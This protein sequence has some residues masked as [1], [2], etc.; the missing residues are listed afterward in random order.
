MNSAMLD[1]YIRSYLED[2][3]W[4][5]EEFDRDGLGRIV[6]L[7][8][9]ARDQNRQILLVGNGGS[10]AAASHMACDLG[11]GTIN[12]DDSAFRRF[13]V[14]SLSDNN[15]LI[16][17]IGNDLSYEEVFVEQLRMLMNT[18]DVVVFISSSGNSPNLLRAAEYAK[19]NGAVTVGLLGFGGGKLAPMMDVPLVVSSRNYGVTEDF[20]LSVQHI[21]TQY[22]RRALAGRAR[23][24]A[25]LDRDGIIN[26]RAA[27][28][29]YLERW[30]DFRF[31]D[32][33]IALLKDLSTRG[34]SLVVVTNQQGVGKGRMTVGD[35]R[36]LH[37]RMTAQ[38]SAEGVHLEGIFTCTHLE[39]RRCFCRK[40][41]PGLIY[42]AINELPFL[43]DL[44]SSLIIGDSPSD[45]AAGQAAGI[46]TRLLISSV[47]D[48]AATHW[49]A[50][51]A[52]ALTLMQAGR[53]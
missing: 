35:L 20:H 28:H 17:A 22:L 11:K 16:T 39:E 33:A 38:L 36:T 5:M 27:P 1:I 2:L 23:P 9:S 18:G 4:T 26:E 44:Q 7:L 25:F 37:E 49:S 15:A 24:V 51:L 47:S 52:G 53:L 41:A 42:R 45:V 50:D 14:I 43:V 31:R 12:F 13:R 32:G 29:H 19:A 21:Y 30:E 34:F 10:A 8:Q 6:E 46:P 40:P 3:K 48:G